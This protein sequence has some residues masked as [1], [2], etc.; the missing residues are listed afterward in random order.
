[1]GAF[2]PRAL[3]VNTERVSKLLS[4]ITTGTFS[5]M[6]PAFSRAILSKVFPKNLVWSR[7]IFVIID[8]IGVIILVQSSRPPSPTSIIAISIWQS[9]KY[10]NAIAVVSSKKLGCKGSKKERYF[11]TKSITY[12]SLI[13]TPLTLILSLKSMRCGL[14]YNPTLYPSVCK[15]DAKV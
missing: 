11:S 3:C 9:A 12:D 2:S 14:V 15:I 13:Q 1:M 4:P 8:N 7:L 6:M 5:L 10:L